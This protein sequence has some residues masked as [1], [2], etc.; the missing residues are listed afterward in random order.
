MA[1]DADD[2]GTAPEVIA[3]AM[4][5]LDVPRR[6]LAA[7][8][9]V[10]AIA[11]DHSVMNREGDPVD[12]SMARTLAWTAAMNG[13]LLLDRLN[14]G[15][16]VAGAVLGEQVTRALLIGWGAEPALLDRAVAAV[17]GWKVR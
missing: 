8:V 7:A 13:A 11:A 12:S 16:P 1:A 3:A 5:V 17:D 6:L 9:E 2:D 10:G 14:V 4:A 15:S